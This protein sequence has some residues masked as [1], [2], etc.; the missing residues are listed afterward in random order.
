MDATTLVNDPTKIH[1]AEDEDLELLSREVN[2]LLVLCAS[3]NPKSQETADA[4]LSY[5]AEVY[6]RSPICANAAVGAYVYR[7][8]DIVTLVK[9]ARARR[10]EVSVGGWLSYLKANTLGGNPEHHRNFVRRAAER[11]CLWMGKTPEET[12]RHLDS[13]GLLE[14]WG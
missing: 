7:G 11:A 14:R 6:K 3:F 12:R 9:R 8:G 10:K 5:C 13:Y 4:F 2:E 1:E